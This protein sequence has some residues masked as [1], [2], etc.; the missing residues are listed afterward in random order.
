MRKP[1]ESWNF[2]LIYSSFVAILAILILGGMILSPSEPSNSLFLGLS[3]PRL[4]LATGL[5][6]AFV[7]FALISIK[8]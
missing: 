6:I 4:V 5:L 8:A 7:F 2:F 1:K 3:L